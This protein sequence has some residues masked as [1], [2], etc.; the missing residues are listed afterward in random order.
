MN[1]KVIGA[2]CDTCNKL[3]ENVLKQPL[4]HPQETGCDAD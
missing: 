4:H 1:I 2:G 3:Y